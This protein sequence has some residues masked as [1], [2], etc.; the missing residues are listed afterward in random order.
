MPS[1]KAAIGCLVLGYDGSEGSRAAV[2]WALRE[3]APN[4]TLVIVHAGRPL[5]APPSPLSSAQERA[6]TGHAI[7][8]ELMLESDA[9][10]FDVE[11]VN[12]VSDEDPVTALLTAA[13]RHRA[14]AIVTGREQH[15]RLHRAVGTV[16]SELQKRSPVPV[17]VVPADASE[18]AA[19]ARGA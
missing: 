15:S 3:L 9:G 18:Q 17:I 2:S 12:E 4:G 8:D 5:H 13:E 16:T 6:E 11:V 7:L 19:A 1:K 14:N 10:T